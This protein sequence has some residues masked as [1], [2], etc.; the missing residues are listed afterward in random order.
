[1]LIRPPYG[2]QA[3]MPVSSYRTSST[4]GAP[5]GAGDSRNGVQS[6]TESRTSRLTTPLNFRVMDPTFVSGDGVDLTLIG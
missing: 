4:F 5:S 6:A 2:D 1:M 3:A